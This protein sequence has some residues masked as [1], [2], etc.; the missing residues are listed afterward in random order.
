MESSNSDPN[1]QTGQGPY[2][3]PYLQ[4]HGTDQQLMQGARTHD[5]YSLHLVPWKIKDT[6]QK[7]M[8]LQE[9]S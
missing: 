6:R 4:T 8:W 7:P 2:W 5:Q 9:A 1:T 3:P